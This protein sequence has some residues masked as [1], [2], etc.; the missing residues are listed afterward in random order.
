MKKL[1]IA[2]MVM[3]CAGFMQSGLAADKLGVTI[4]K[5]DDNFMATMR[6]A[7]EEMNKEKGSFNMLMKDSQN[8]PSVEVT[9]VTTLLSQG[10]KVLAINI[11]DPGTGKNMIKKIK[12]DEV[13]V[14]FFNRDIGK[15]ALATYKD[16][17]FVGTDPKQ[18]GE[19]QGNLIAKKWAAHPEWDKNKDGKVQYVLLKGEPG[20]PDAEARTEW[21]KK[22]MEAKGLKIDE[23]FLD[24]AMWDTAKATNKMQ[25]WLAS[26]KGKEIEVVIANND[27]MAMGAV[28]A[29][30]TEGHLLPTFGVDALQEALQMVKKGDLQGTVLNDGEGQSKAVYAM[31]ENLAKGKPATEGTDL[32]MENNYVLIPYVGVDKA[33]LDKFLKT[34]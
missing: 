33:N 6:Q 5:Y 32:K 4:Y 13:P 15:E 3:A 22:A 24:T 27:A 7:L 12:D 1:K 25:T 2:A 14:I 31:A 11:V 29:M 8:S 21:V 10:V 34:K 9:N 26:P 19:I 28:A 20:H 23:L 17:Y 16:A 30:K 18:S